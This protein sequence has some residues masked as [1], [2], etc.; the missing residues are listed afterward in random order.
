MDELAG[1]KVAQNMNI[2]ITGSVGI[3]IRACQSG[4]I[5]V[6][7]AE[8]AFDSIRKANRHLSEKMIGRAIK[9]I[10]DAGRR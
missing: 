2:P 5:T 6:Q 10:H 9:L 8:D 3:L 7:E 1:R 4:C